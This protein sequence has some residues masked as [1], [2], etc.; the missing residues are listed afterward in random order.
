MIAVALRGD[1]HSDARELKA[2]PA[3]TTNEPEIEQ[4]I[5]AQVSRNSGR[6]IC[7]RER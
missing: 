1:N 6:S 5:A 3:A 4:E 7:H 2:Q